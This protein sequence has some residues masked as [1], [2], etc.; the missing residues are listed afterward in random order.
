M[1]YKEARTKFIQSWG[2]LATQ[3][4]INKTMAQIHALMMIS[5][6][7]LS[8]DQIME[9]LQISR[10][11]VSMNLRELISWGIVYKEYKTGDRKDYYS[12]E[13]DFTELARKI[14][15]E[16]S[17]RE[18]KPII[19]VLSE[20]RQVEEEGEDVAY[21]L[22]K[23]EELEDLIS[24]AD[25]LIDKVTRKKGNWLTQFVVKFLK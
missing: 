16:R 13:K 3:W 17:R 15:I 12:S 11:N 7:P 10:G 5:A 20:V 8:V 6:E 1:K 19:S 23:T 21:F 24:M 9:E 4:G 18:I 25:G 14:A 22:E 2:A